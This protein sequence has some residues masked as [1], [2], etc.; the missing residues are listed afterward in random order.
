MPEPFD[1][2][3]D[4]GPLLLDVLAERNGLVVH[5]YRYAGQF[6]FRVSHRASG[7]T[8]RERL[9]ATQEAAERAMN[10]LADKADWTAFTT[11]ESV[12]P[13]CKRAAIDA[14]IAG[15]I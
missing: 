3:T 15:V 6:G 7:Y 10:Y 1:A 14:Q 4:Q 2:M 11:P 13:E 9:F 5:R 12:T 8:V